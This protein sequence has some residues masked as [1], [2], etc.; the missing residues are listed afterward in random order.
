MR[1]G[2]QLE[3]EL[4][5]KQKTKVSII[6]GIFAL[7]VMLVFASVFMGEMNEAKDRLDVCHSAG[8]D[9]YSDVSGFMKRSE[10]KCYKEVSVGTGYEYKY[11]GYIFKY[12]YRK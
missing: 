7:L 10:Y 12:G 5:M 8:Y 6:S 4:K 2:Y 9:G 1:F 3:G 11:S